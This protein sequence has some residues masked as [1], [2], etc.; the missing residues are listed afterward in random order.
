MKRI[1]V[2]G[3]A[4]FIGSKVSDNLVNDGYEVFTIDNLSTGYEENLPSKVKFIEGD[5]SDNQ[6]TDQ[7]LKYQFDSIIHIAGQSSGEISFEDPERDLRDNALSTLNLLNF[8]TKN[9]CR[10]F[11]YASTMSVYGDVPNHII[12]ESNETK[13]LSMYAVGKL[14]SEN[15]LRIYHNLGIRTVSLR[16]FNV[17]GPGQNM[18][19]LKQG[20]ISIYLSQVINDKK[21]VVKGSPDRFRDFVY[22]DDVVK[23]FN[24]FNK[25]YDF[26]SYE[27]FNISTGI[28][29]E[30]KELLEK[31]NS[32]LQSRVPVSFKQGTL[33]DQ[34]GIYGDNSKLL[35]KMKNFTFMSL[36][37]GLNEFLEFLE[38]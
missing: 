28:K 16:L 33:G 7:L 34:F 15:Y 26:K 36:D 11:I 37:E 8:A 22:I 31:I 27:N 10:K 32:K 25:E 20:M 19:N 1:L 21:I 18:Q 5:C 13:P 9:N 17:Y 30:V 23:V 3:G 14:A 4:G 6:L 29:T 24:F 12:N 38:I 2:T 35:I